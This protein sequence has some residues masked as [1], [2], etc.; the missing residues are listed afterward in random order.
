MSKEHK[1]Y[2]EK[3]VTGEGTVEEEGGASVLL[4]PLTTGVL[5]CSREGLDFLYV[6]MYIYITVFVC[7]KT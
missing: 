2:L 3:A 6:Y 1:S 7:I 4:R 5:G